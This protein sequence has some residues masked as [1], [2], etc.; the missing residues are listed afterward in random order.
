MGAITYNEIMKE[1]MHP[2]LLS[3]LRNSS[4]KWL[5]VFFS[6]GGDS[7][8]FFKVEFTADDCVLLILETH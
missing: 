1:M 8:S 7:S 6:V 3:G 2:N 5:H 4:V